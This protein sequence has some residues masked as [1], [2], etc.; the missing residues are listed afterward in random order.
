MQA[1]MRAEVMERVV[2]DV[3][4]VMELDVVEKEVEMAILRFKNKKAPG[5]DEIKAEVLKRVKDVIKKDMAQLL[6][7]VRTV[8]VFP[9]VWKTGLVKLIK[10]GEDK[11]IEEIK[12]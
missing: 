7:Q 3:G 10:K 12:S 4:E 5:E 11:P 1:R 2:E 6:I 8:G 9:E